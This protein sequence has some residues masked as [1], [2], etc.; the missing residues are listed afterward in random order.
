MTTPLYR[1]PPYAVLPA[2]HPLA[3]RSSIRVA[4]VIA[5]PMVLI[6]LLPSAEFFIDRL[7]AAGHDADIRYRTASVETIRSMVGRGLG[8]GI[9][10]HKPVTPTTYDGG[11]VSEVDLEDLGDP[12][13]VLLVRHTSAR[14]TR[15]LEAFIAVCRDVFREPAHGALATR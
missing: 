14:P 13:D 8:W 1:C 3:D 15:R 2:D 7:T 6:D 12:I 5:E 10:L 4:E 9:L 11:R